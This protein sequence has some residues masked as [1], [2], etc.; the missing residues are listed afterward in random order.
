MGE[1]RP[2]QFAIF[3][4]CGAP[5]LQASGV[6]TSQPPS[7]TALAGLKEAMDAGIG[8]GQHARLLFARDGMSLAYAW[9]KSGF[10]LPRHS[11]DSDCLYF[12]LGG[13]LRIGKETLKAGDGFFVGKGVPYT[14]TPGD[15]GVEVL[16]FRATGQFD[17]K[18]LASNMAF[19]T[20]AAQKVEA[21]QT[22]WREESLSP[23]GLFDERV[24][25]LS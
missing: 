14:Y 22:S 8:N 16:E 13:T 9:F 21:K 1:V 10:P 11:H 18:V 25:A 24:G 7:Q 2:S 3:R 12:I 5:D 23:S 15:A 6:M 17:V 4:G 20:T 19:W